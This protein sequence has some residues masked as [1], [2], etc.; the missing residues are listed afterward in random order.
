MTY[1][2]QTGKNTPVL[3]TSVRFNLVEIVDFQG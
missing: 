3:V 2:D 1:S